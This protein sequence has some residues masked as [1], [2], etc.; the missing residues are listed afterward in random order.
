MARVNSIGCAPTNSTVPSGNGTQFNPLT[1][2]S[3]SVVSTLVSR[4][5]SSNSF[6][7]NAVRAY[8]VIV[9]ADDSTALIAASAPQIKF[10]GTLN[11]TVVLPDVSTF[12]QAGFAFQFYNE[13]TDQITVLSYGE[14]TV[15]VMEPNSFA[16]FT[17]NAITGTDASVWDVLYLDLGDV[18]N[19]ITTIAGDSGSVTGSTVTFTGS[20]SGLTFSGSSST[21]T[22]GGTL[23]LASGG[24]NAS[25]TASNGGIFYSTASAGAILAGTATANQ[26]LMSGSSSAPSWSTATYPA[27]T[28]ANRIL[29]SSADN[30]VGQITSANNGILITSSSG[31]PSFLANGTAGYV[32]T[33]QSGAPPAWAAA[34]AGG[35]TYT[36][37]SSAP[38][39]AN[40]TT[41][42]ATAALTVTLPSAPADGYVVG[43]MNCSS[44]SVV[45]QASGSDVI[46]LS[47][48]VSSAAGTATSSIKG[49]SMILVYQASGNT[50]FAPSGP[51]GTSWDLA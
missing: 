21:M 14:D 31:V 42:M 11:Q 6:F 51:Q 9:T 43:L 23:N 41:Y 39:T 7:N 30:T 4:D 10:T 46:Q 25:L 35:M 12:D 13:S 33:A 37:I 50:W 8:A 5:S 18:A 34:S 49:E 45:F 38:T 32:L 36:S 22:L 26:L 47:D 29:Y 1:Y 3:S 17:A 19:A 27:S 24:T 28:T 48:V 44:G 20:G 16:T 15:K 2:G 40:K